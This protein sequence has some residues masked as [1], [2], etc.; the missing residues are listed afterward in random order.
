MDLARDLSTRERHVFAAN[1]HVTLTLGEMKN[2][3]ARLEAEGAA[4]STPLSGKTSFGGH[5]LLAVT[6]TIV[7]FG[8]PEE[9]ARG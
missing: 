8:D 7:R 6:A 9:R 2:F 5:R 1:R 3:I 4:Y